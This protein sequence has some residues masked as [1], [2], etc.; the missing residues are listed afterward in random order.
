MSSFQAANRE[1]QNRKI[2]EDLQMKKQ[3]LLKQGAAPNSPPI[4]NSMSADQLQHQRA[5][6]ITANAQSTG[7]YI[8][9]DS[10][11]GNIV[12]PVLPR[13]DA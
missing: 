10:S 13:Y 3:L 1:L 8:T 9:Q 6:L 5:A 2:L 4:S 7:F 11:F 12:L